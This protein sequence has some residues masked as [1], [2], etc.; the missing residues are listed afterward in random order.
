MGARATCMLA[1][2]AVLALVGS[3]VVGVAAAGPAGAGAVGQARAVAGTVTEA[4]PTPS[5]V[6]TP[7]QVST[8]PHHAC[9]VTSTGA[10]ACWGTSFV[11]E[12]LPPSGTFTSV[13]AGTDFSTLQSYSCGVQSGGALVCWGVVADTVPTGT[14]TAVTATGLDH[15]ACALRTTGVAVCF[16][17]A[18]PTAPSDAF[19]TISPG[20][21]GPTGYV[22]GVRQSDSHLECWGD[23]TAGVATPPAGT[24]TSVSAGYTHACAV[25]TDHTVSCWGQAAASDLTPATPNS[26]TSVAAGSDFSCGVHTDGTLACWGTDDAFGQVHPPQGTYQSVSAGPDYACAVRTDNLVACWGN[27]T[28]GQTSPPASG[29]STL[30]PGDFQPCALL[31]TG[32]AKC[33]GPTSV[34]TYVPPP[35]GTFSSVAEG[36]NSQFACGLRPDATLRCWGSEF[37]NPGFGL[38]PP[39]G[40]YLSVATAGFAGCAVRTD[41]NLICWGGTVTVPSSGPFVAVEMGSNSV[42]G[43]RSDQT[44]SCSGAAAPSVAMTQVSVGNT[45]ACGTGTDQALRC[46]GTNTHGESTPPSGSFLAVAAGGDQSCAIKSDHTVA[47]WGGT[48]V[49][50]PTQPNPDVVPPTGTYTAIGAGDKGT[51]AVETTGVF[52]CWGT[53][54]AA[55]GPAIG[56]P[57][58]TAPPSDKFTPLTPVRILDSRPG[59]GNTGGYTSPWGTGTVRTVAVGGHG[60]VPANADAVVLNV[61]VADTTRSSYLTAWPAGQP[62]PTASNLNWTA[63]EVIPNAVT[64]KLGT[65]GDISV[66]NQA[67]NTDVIIDV[68]GYYQSTTGDGFTSVAP[69]RILDSRPGSGNTGGYTSPWGTGTVRTVAVGSHGGVPANA[70]AVVL[71]VT[72][73]DTTGSS[74]L[75]AWPAGQSQPTASNLNW[76]AGEVIPNAVTVKLG[77][78]GD[79]SV[80]NHVG[81]AD[82]IID[83]AGY[84]QS[85]TG[86]A[87]HPIT[88]ARALDSRPGS[89]NTGAYSTPWTTGT[90]RSTELADQVAVPAQATAV[91]LNVTVADTT[92]SSYLTLWPTGQSQ[93]TA[94]NLNWVP[95]EVI[96]NAVT[97]K[98]GTGGALGIFNNAGNVDVIVDAAG[99]FG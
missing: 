23:N 4:V 70:D 87:F 54:D 72:V 20:G 90:S 18:A 60:G 10:L 80:F 32:T 3:L 68:A 39:A 31:V 36:S 27:D 46:W 38:T 89:G 53:F 84:Y 57:L 51:C 56:V 52:Q 26:Y 62:Q 66:F 92:G 6:P 76:I 64:V 29:L 63:G 58:A 13:A 40:T 91:V 42:C 12:S 95:G 11:G 77:T 83:V 5:A 79:I 16:G 75:T 86:A 55:A 35:P 2:A 69:A 14:F 59:S 45:H 74:Y 9:A 73:A 30:V 96:P 21:S 8:G 61:T 88:P 43:E 47:C 34:N 93:P 28:N 78:N 99:W 85:G 22:C 65:N 1:A 50:Y 71:N 67:G 7:A 15:F 97:V 94:S 25:A 24:F 33:W 41:H 17:S 48:P 98:L 37:G 81:S 44:W 82:V 19:T 49:G